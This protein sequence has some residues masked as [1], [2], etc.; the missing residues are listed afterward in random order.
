MQDRAID[1]QDRRPSTIVDVAREAGVSFKTVSRALNGEPNARDATRQRVM[2][3]AR[4]LGYRANPYARNL[5][6]A[7]SRLIAVFFSNPSRNY[8]SEIQVGVLERCNAEGFNAIFE[9]AE[10]DLASFVSLRGETSLA[11]AILV[12]PLS[13]NTALLDRLRSAGIPFVRLSPI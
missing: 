3:A 13:E 10:G 7:Q 4:A 1:S 11:G 8:T 12:P 5:R 6:A 9:Q 2:D